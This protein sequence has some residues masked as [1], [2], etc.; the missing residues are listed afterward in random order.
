M[1][2]DLHS[3]PSRMFVTLSPPR[4]EVSGQARMLWNRGFT[5]ACSAADAEF[6]F[7]AAVGGRDGTV[8]SALGLK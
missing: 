7:S 2:I 1:S 5:D 8:L 3:K 6:I 4:G